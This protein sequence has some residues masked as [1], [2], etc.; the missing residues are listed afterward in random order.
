[1]ADVCLHTGIPVDCGKCS[2]IDDRE[3][4]LIVNR[5]NDYLTVTKTELL[6]Y[7]SRNLWYNFFIGM[8]T[9]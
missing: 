1:M 9:K 8:G 7:C 3:N 4:S 2:K 5:A 6:L